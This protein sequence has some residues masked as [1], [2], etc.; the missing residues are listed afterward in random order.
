MRFPFCNLTTCGAARKP[1]LFIDRA[2]ISIALARPDPTKPGFFGRVAKPTREEIAIA[3]LARSLRRM[4][5]QSSIAQG[6]ADR[7]LNEYRQRLRRRPFAPDFYVMMMAEA[8]SWQDTKVS[9]VSG[10]MKTATRNA[11]IG[12]I[13][14]DIRS[15]EW[16]RQVETIREIY[17]EVCA[18]EG[19]E[20]AKKAVKKLKEKLPGFLTSGTFS[21]RDSAYLVEHSGLLCCDLDECSDIEA[22]RAKLAVDLFVAAFFASPTW[23]GLKVILRIRPDASSHLRSFH[24]AREHFRRGYSLEID[25]CQ[26]LARICFVSHDPELFMRNGETK[27]LEPLPEEEPKPEQ[28]AQG[29]PDVELTS[30]LKTRIERYLAKVDPAVQGEHG[31]DLTYYVACILAWRFALSFNDAKPFM[32]SYS[33]RC[34]PPWSETEIDHKLID[35]RKATDHREKRGHLLGE[36]SSKQA[37]PRI[38]SARQIFETPPDPA[39]TLLGNRFLCR[40]GAMLFVGPSGIG[41]SSASAQQDIFW[42]NGLPAFGIAP[43]HPLRILII[44]AEDDDGDLHE[45]TTGVARGLELS[46][47]QIERYFANCCGYVPEKA[48]T[49]LAFINEVVEPLLKEH[50]PDILRINPFQAYLGGD[51]TKP[52]VTAAFLRNGL[53]PLLDRFNCGLILVHHTPKVTNRDT[54]EWRASDWM[55]AGAGAADVTNWTRSALVIDATT[56]PQVFKFIAAKR[57]SRIGWVDDFTGEREF[58]R[59]FAHGGDGKICW[60]DASEEEAQSAKDAPRKALDVLALVPENGSI[61]KNALL[62]KAGDLAP[63]IGVNKARGFIAQLV[64]DGLLFEWFVSR[65]RT[66]PEA[67]LARYE[68]TPI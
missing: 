5:A 56:N 44:Q 11:T 34:L 10:A 4:V 59:Y 38:V 3:A 32:R 12:G 2:E 25:D 29:C 9:M 68:Q 13:L 21:K 52:E 39:Q 1:L 28:S 17:A 46:G 57:A 60:H 64:G 27:I 62:S 67:H 26:D 48:R 47:E 31:S 41:K 22:V 43:P 66:A 55:Y 7:R 63:P 58:V 49:G 65:P 37:P 6:E 61:S 30:E 24:A 42:C 15:G 23:S 40:G 50:R 14:E 35:A 51:I 45:M 53:N 33:K 18:M 54:T 20:E 36:P 8:V 16:A 19:R